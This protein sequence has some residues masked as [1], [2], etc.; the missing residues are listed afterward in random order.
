VRPHSHS[1]DRFS[2]VTALELTP[3]YLRCAYDLDFLI[4]RQ[5]HNSIKSYHPTRAN[6]PQP[7]ELEYLDVFDLFNFPRLATAGAD[8]LENGNQAQV[9]DQ[10]AGASDLATMIPNFAVPDPQEDWLFHPR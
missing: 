10:A 2:I 1:P 4:S 3:L 5:P 8:G 9:L 6:T 7:N